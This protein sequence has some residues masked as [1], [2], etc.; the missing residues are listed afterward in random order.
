MTLQPLN[1]SL[2]PERSRTRV[3]DRMTA[4]QWRRPFGMVGTFGTARRDA[5]T[6]NAVDAGLH[7][8]KVPTVGKAPHRPP[9]T[10]HR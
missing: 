8:A 9:G 6:I 10:V 1:R 2:P 7:I 3:A 4:A 5:D